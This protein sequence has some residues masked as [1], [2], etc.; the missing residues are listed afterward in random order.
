MG[1]DKDPTR[2]PLSATERVLEVLAEQG[3]PLG[4]VRNID[5][6]SYFPT[7]EGRARFLDAC[8]AAGFRLNA[9]YESDYDENRFAVIVCHDDVPDGDVL[10]KVH[11]MLTELAEREGG[12]YDGWETQVMA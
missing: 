5:H 9:T 4:S 7:T 3:D 12:R 6:F 2:I 1:D 11:A 8:L 10:L